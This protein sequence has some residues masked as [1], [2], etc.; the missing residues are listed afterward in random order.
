MTSR[1]ACLLHGEP[2]HPEAPWCCA[3]CGYPPD[4]CPEESAISGGQEITT[5]P[6]SVN[7]LDQPSALEEI[8]L[9]NGLPPNPKRDGWHWIGPRTDRFVAKWNAASRMWSW[10]YGRW[11]V[12][13]WQNMPDATRCA[14][15]AANAW[16]YHG[17]CPAPRKKRPLRA[18][19]QPQGASA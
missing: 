5:N 12:W 4:A 16:V 14:D 9:W 17:R 10:D 19:G 2:S 18:K 13:H 8:A 3:Q 11:Y 15:S 6:S 1:D 7:E